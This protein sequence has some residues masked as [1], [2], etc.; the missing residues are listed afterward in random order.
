[1]KFY[2]AGEWQDR[3][4]VIEVCNP[5]RGDV[6]DTVAV[7]TD[8]GADEA[9]VEQLLKRP[10]GTKLQLTIEESLNLSVRVSS[11]RF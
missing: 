2:L 4:A 5:F 8:T 11:P 10:G 3:D 7:A 9:A 1:M 6:I